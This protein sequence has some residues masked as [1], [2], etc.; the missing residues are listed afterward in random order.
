[1]EVDWEKTVMKDGFVG[2]DFTSMEVL[3]LEEESVWVG[4]EARGNLGSFK[5]VTL[6]MVPVFCWLRLE[7]TDINEM[8]RNYDKY[9]KLAENPKPSNSVDLDTLFD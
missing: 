8:F 3:G 9:R 4:K 5:I 2:Y 1:M 7:R 6:V